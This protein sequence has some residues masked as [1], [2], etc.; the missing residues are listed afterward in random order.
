MNYLGDAEMLEEKAMN[1][2]PVRVIVLKKS[3]ILS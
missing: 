1:R 2:S 3:I